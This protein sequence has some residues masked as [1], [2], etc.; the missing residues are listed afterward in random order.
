MA[1]A[2]GCASPY[3]QVGTRYR[4]VG[5]VTRQHRISASSEPLA[6]G[7][8]HQAESSRERASQVHVDG[9]SRPCPDR[10]CC[11]HS[12]PASGMN[13]FEAGAEGCGQTRSP[14]SVTSSEKKDRCFHLLLSFLVIL[15]SNGN[16]N[17]TIRRRGTGAPPGF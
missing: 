11:G 8:G 13:L 12:H 15:K 2:P 10:W 4:C 3:F 9:G 14:S 16:K 5:G 17:R 1:R 6:T 7:S